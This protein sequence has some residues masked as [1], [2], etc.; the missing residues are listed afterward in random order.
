MPIIMFAFLFPNWQDWCNSVQLSS[1]WHTIIKNHRSKQIQNIL[2][3][4]MLFTFTWYTCFAI[5]AGRDFHERVRLHRKRADIAHLIISLTLWKWGTQTQT[6]K[7]CFYRLFPNTV[8]DFCLLQN[9]LFFSP[10]YKSNY[11]KSVCRIQ[12][13]LLCCELA[14]FDQLSDTCT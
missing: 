4:I 5:D 8:T 2:L 9:V 3:H 12:P 14:L 6:D 11:R 10:I 7:G 1:P 13:W